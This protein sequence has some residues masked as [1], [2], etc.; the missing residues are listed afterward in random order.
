MVLLF[1]NNGMEEI[2]DHCNSEEN[3]TQ[4]LVVL[5]YLSVVLTALLR[6]TNN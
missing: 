4:C 2:K 1:K 5:P 3:F 6:S